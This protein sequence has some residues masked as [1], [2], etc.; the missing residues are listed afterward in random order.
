M[1]SVQVSVQ[2]QCLAAH[3][4][5]RRKVSVNIKQ[6]KQIIDLSKNDDTEK[7]IMCNLLLQLGKL[8][9]VG[10]SYAPSVRVSSMFNKIYEKWNLQCIE[11]NTNYTTHID[12]LE[13]INDGDEL[14]L[15]CGDYFSYQS[16][17]VVR[18]HTIH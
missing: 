18:S 12:R 10:P 2:L 17:A 3:N 14:I 5:E 1:I 8:L 4:D 15:Y 7:Y 11:K 6:T 16:T 13:D 9:G